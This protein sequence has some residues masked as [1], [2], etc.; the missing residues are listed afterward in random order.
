MRARYRPWKFLLFIML[1][2]HVRGGCRSAISAIH[3][4]RVPPPHF[5]V[6]LIVPY[7]ATNVKY[8]HGEYPED[9]DNW[10]KFVYYSCHRLKKGVASYATIYHWGCT[11]NEVEWMRISDLPFPT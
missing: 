2:S 11:E 5:L 10:E 1:A 3:L 4:F 8:F 6:Y 9:I 7:L